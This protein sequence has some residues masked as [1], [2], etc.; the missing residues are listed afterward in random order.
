MGEDKGK[1][2]LNISL[3]GV[4]QV[5]GGLKEIEG[6]SD[7]VAGKTEQATGRMAQSNQDLMS[8]YGSLKTIMTAVAGSY[9]FTRLISEANSAIN[10]IDSLRI[11]TIQI[12]AQITTMQGPKNVAEHYA[13]A[14]KY[15][16]ALAVKLQE[17]DANSFANYQTLLQMAQTMTL[18]GVVM[19]VNNK[20]Q[21]DAFTSLSNAVAMYTAGQNQSVQA[22][23]EI[24]AL[25]SGEVTQGSQ[26]AMQINDMTKASGLYKNGLKELV[27]EGKNHGDTLERLAPFLVG[28]NAASGD[29]ATTWQAVTASAATAKFIIE[30]IGF[31]EL[32][33]DAIKF[34]GEMVANLKTQ[35]E[36]IGS[37]IARGWLAVKGIL[38][39]ISIL[40]NQ[41]DGSLRGIIAAARY[42]VEVTNSW[43][44]GW[45]F[46]ISTVLPT[47]AE[48]FNSIVNILNAVVNMAY[49]FGGILIDGIMGA[50]Q[51]VSHLSSAIMQIL[52]GDF[53]GAKNS[54]AKIFGSDFKAVMDGD[55]AVVKGTVA[56]IK[57]EWGKLKDTSSFNNRFDKFIGRTQQAGGPVT[58]PVLPPVP[59]KPEAIDNTAVEEQNKYADFY[60]KLQE[61]LIA[62]TPLQEKFDKSIEKARFEFAKMNDEVAPQY[63][64]TLKGLQEQVLRNMEVN[65]ELARSSQ[66]Q[67]DSLKKEREEAEKLDQAYARMREHYKQA[68]DLAAIK[69]NTEDLNIELIQD[70]GAQQAA[71]ITKQYD[72]KLQA[73]Q[74]YA[75]DLKLIE[76]KT[77]EDITDRLKANSNLQIAIVMAKNDKLLAA[78]AEQAQKIRDIQNQTED[79]NISMIR[80]PFEQK[81]AQIEANY[82]REKQAIED[83]I[84][85]LTAAN[86]IEV[87]QIV[88]RQ[89]LVEEGIKREFQLRGGPEYAAFLEREKGLDND[90]W[91][92]L[93]ANAKKGTAEIAAL[94]SLLTALAMK[95]D[96]DLANNSK[97]AWNSRLMTIASVIDNIG[98]VLMQGNKDQFEA[99]K[100]M[101]ITSTIISTYLG[102]QQ[103][104]TALAG[105]PIVGPALGVAAAAAAVVS[106]LARVSQIE[107]QEYQASYAVGSKELPAD[108]IA[109]VHK[110][111]MIIDASSANVLRKY[112][113][114]ISGAADNYET[115][116]ALGP[117]FGS[118]QDLRK[119][120]D[121]N[122]LAVARV[123]DGLTKISGSLKDYG[124]W[125]ADLP[126]V[127]T[128]EEK[129]TIMDAL[130]G[131]FKSWAVSTKDLFSFNIGE[132]LRASFNVA[133]LG[134]G[135]SLANGL[136][137]GDRKITGQGIQLGY[138]GGLY[139]G[140][141][142]NI[143]TDGGWFS[144]DK[145]STVT[146]ALPGET[147]RIIADTVTRIRQ[148]TLTAAQVLG[149]GTDGILA[150]ILPLENIDLRNLDADAASKKIEEW[151]QKLA[152][153]FAG[154]VSGLDALRQPGEE[155]FDALARLAGA[156]QT[157]NEKAELIG[158]R[159]VS[160]SLAN[161]DA[162][163]KLIDAM[164]G[165][166]KY[167]DKTA[168]FFDTFYTDGEKSRRTAEQATRQM[169]VAFRDMGMIAPTTREGFAR[170]VE[171]LDITT[172][173]GR[174]MYAAM[175]DIADA[176]DKAY[177][178]T[179]ELIKAQKES[180][181]DLTLRELAVNG[182]DAAATLLDLVYKQQ[183]ELADY[184]AKGLDTTRLLTLQQL[185]YEQAVKDVAETLKSASNDMAATADK[186][187]EKL[188]AAV[189]AQINIL[190]TLKTLL[191]GDLS[192]LSPADKY[193]QI[194]ATFRATAGRAQLGDVSA[195]EQV[196][197]LAQDFLSSSR[198]YNASGPAYANDF[199]AVTRTLAELAGLPTAT[200]IQIDV[201]QKQLET[202]QRIHDL[203]SA[204]NLDQVLVKDV[205]S[206]EQMT[207]MEQKGLIDKGNADQLTVKDLISSGNVD[208]LT[209]L[210]SIL[211]EN[212][213]V[214]QLLQQYLQADQAAKD[215]ATQAAT[216]ALA[217]AE[218]EKQRLAALAAAR[219]ALSAAQSAY[220]TAQ[221]QVTAAQAALDAVI[222]PVGWTKDSAGAWHQTAE[223]TSDIPPSSGTWYDVTGGVH[224]TM[225]NNGYIIQNL[226]THL[227]AALLAAANALEQLN[228]AQSAYG[229]MPQYADGSSY[230]AGDQTAR[231]HHE[232][233][234][235]DSKS[236]NVLRKYGIQV[237]GGGG[238][239]E[240]V[241]LLKSI[242]AKLDRLEKL[243]QHAAAGVR[244]QA[245]GLNRLVRTGEE[246][247][248]SMAGIESKARLE[249]A[250]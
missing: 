106:G 175:M 233:M 180:N 59:G 50:L 43:L 209:Y 45:A 96:W 14:T 216:D 28:I 38:E 202:L 9:V 132:S 113:I 157:V 115:V 114:N 66:A 36:Y 171:G 74:R 235:V 215:A 80:D 214:A 151:M 85:F 242:D 131:G 15:A 236:A 139:G 91:K 42:V 102:A 130:N 46:L 55:L 84:K 94:Q 167:Q 112:G 63:R 227:S 34:G 90:K 67:Q 35:A 8:S 239:K 148:T 11:S 6:A 228:A 30:S 186:I 194:S 12:A 133:F 97:E 150:A 248:K 134:F 86:S 58:A 47:A 37:G 79:I 100:A 25:M 128:K 22:H 1:V 212:S 166:E 140:Q 155:S 160:S 117:L 51:A 17:V 145:N 196:S 206:Q 7:S 10:A 118:M 168:K 78:A 201:A 68:D 27:A 33:Q 191:G 89:K 232:E 153:A 207:A 225:V 53:V 125:F 164:G 161:A 143:R 189:A 169:N 210:K 104:F 3:D 190:G 24:R 244:V 237:N 217:T 243:E 120:I 182:N 158:G 31:R 249:A 76:K 147:E 152:N 60:N 204:G 121:N 16:G 123:D 29:I 136:F 247:A 4:P 170:I 250:A 231:I 172:E 174:R 208:Q 211:G 57:E 56:A 39:T 41:H 241:A 69:S 62:T 109:Q 183:S 54:I 98:Q 83:K 13:E 223:A 221:S 19:D 179:E 245:D 105:I 138:R 77:G 75:R 119:A 220:G 135:H 198:A 129:S 199:A 137:G 218:A 246:Q 197:Q 159:L 103:A 154:G 26:L 81:A 162:A 230:I 213:G 5:V 93:T 203:I 2:K 234:V 48:K 181:Q 49:A 144:S 240:M 82:Q 52:T 92:S 95:K 87:D 141:Y 73:A 127:G 176:A 101:A 32:Y 124:Q 184:Q 61:Q 71:Q 205:L 229:A 238:N 126:G 178:H 18:Q 195:L 219:D 187:K 173:S 107:S 111:E 21:V 188:T 142:A 222:N 88:S 165:V 23:Q 99:G 149:T 226:N 200:E 146:S 192:T 185:E 110:G 156:L 65:Q 108:Q 177:K 193:A 122:S 224:K 70:P 163:S 20:K 116:A 44:E 64:E 72:D 40:F